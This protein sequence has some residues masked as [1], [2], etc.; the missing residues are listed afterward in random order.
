MCMSPENIQYDKNSGK[1][2]FDIVELILRYLGVYDVPL[3]LEDLS[4]KRKPK[5]EFWK[6]KWEILKRSKG[7]IK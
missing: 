3:K 1:I 4:S 5:Y 6:P 7:L 2:S